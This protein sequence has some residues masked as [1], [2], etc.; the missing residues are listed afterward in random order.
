M[1]K[2]GFTLIELLASLVLV[3]VIILLL[4][5]VIFSLNMINNS[6]TYL[7]SDEINRIEIIKLIEHDINTLKLKD[8]EIEENSDFTN[9]IFKYENDTK[10][11]K[12]LTN[13]LEYNNEV[14]PLETNHSAYN[15]KPILNKSQIDAN[16]TYLELRI[17]TLIDNNNSS[18]NDDIIINYLGFTN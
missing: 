18:L 12:V 15:L 10:T 1:N 9:I 6:T 7:S 17:E 3:S 13:S 11:L 4:M 8:I 5:R 16:Y 14:Y 2:K